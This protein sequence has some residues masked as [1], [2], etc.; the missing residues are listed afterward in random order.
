[1]RVKFTIRLAEFLMISASRKSCLIVKTDAYNRDQ[2]AKVLQVRA[3]VEGLKLG[4]GVLD[5][6][7]EEGERTSLR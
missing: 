1:M 7:S 6:L 2:I 5:K 4:T 3:N